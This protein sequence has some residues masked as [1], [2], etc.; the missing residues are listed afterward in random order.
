[1]GKSIHDKRI[2]WKFTQ[3]SVDP[4]LYYF[5]YKDEFIVVFVVVDDISF[6][7][8]NT[9]MMKE[10]KQNM[11]TTVNVIFFGKLKSVIRW[12]INRSPSAYHVSQNA[13]CDRLLLRFG[14]EHC[15][16]FRTP[17]LSN[18]D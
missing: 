13:Y 12:S 2:L 14:M 10:F 4:R 18:V 15:N 17:L 7:S 6:D 5:V 16:A 11:G 8:N 1:M 9:R 3:C